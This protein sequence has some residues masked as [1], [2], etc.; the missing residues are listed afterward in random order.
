MVLKARNSIRKMKEWFGSQQHS[1]MPNT[2][3]GQ[4]IKNTIVS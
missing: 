2:R 3:S 4:E 1:A